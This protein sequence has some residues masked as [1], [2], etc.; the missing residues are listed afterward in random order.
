[1]ENVRFEFLSPVWELSV[2]LRCIGKR[3]VLIELFA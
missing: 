3:V 1:M 2:H